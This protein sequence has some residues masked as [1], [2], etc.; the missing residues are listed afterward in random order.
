MHC[1]GP[2]DNIT[3]VRM[4]LQTSIRPVLAVNCDRVFVIRQFAPPLFWA[5]VTSSIRA[6]CRR[7]CHVLR[8]I[9][10]KIEFADFSFDLGYQI[11]LIYICFVVE[12]L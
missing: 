12:T 3:L 8:P 5:K 6:L 4:K 7:K 2:Q 9:R 11:S 1:T 10:I